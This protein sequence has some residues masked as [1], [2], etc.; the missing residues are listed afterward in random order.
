M[1]AQKIQ[2][3]SLATVIFLSWFGAGK[4]PKAPG[5]MGSLATL[6][7]VFLLHHLNL[8]TSH[9]II[10]IT[11]LYV[12]AVIVTQKVQIKFNLK[13]PQWIVID[14]VIGMLIAWSFLQSINI[15]DLLLVFGSFRLFDIIKIW[16]ASW[17]DRLHHGI[18]TISDDV[19]SGLYAGI[20]SLFIRHFF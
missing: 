17:F 2:G 10:F 3:P 4:F 8:N 11:C 1:K 7:L 16:P 9:L 19:V 20:I 5:T 14:E 6:P 15:L 12:A 18:G 13:D